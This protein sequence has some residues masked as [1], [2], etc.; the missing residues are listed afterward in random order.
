MTG[1]LQTAHGPRFPVVIGRGIGEGGAAGQHGV[2][3]SGHL[4]RVS[5]ALRGSWTAAVLKVIE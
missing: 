2:S 4:S 5:R 1:P 3:L